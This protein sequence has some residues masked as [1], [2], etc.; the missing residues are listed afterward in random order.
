[1]KSGLWVRTVKKAARAL[2]RTSPPT[3]TDRG[4]EAGFTLLEMV[5]VVAI[6]AL[7]AAILLPRAPGGTSRPRLEA[8]AVEVATLL[9]ADRTVAM[10][11]RAGVSAQVDARD[12]LVRSGAGGRLVQ[13]PDDVLFEALLPERCNGQSALSTISFFANGMSCGGVIRLVRFGSGFEIR[14]NWLTGEIEI[15]P[16]N[17]I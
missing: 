15:V 14:V 8:Y 6:V 1:M 3:R 7:L 5:C 11:L 13:V 2:L 10:Q 9:K 12:R 17:A 16:R 4:H